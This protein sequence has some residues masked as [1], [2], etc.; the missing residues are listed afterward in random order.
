MISD[1][2]KEQDFYTNYLG[3]EV[4]MTHQFSGPE[5]EKIVGLPP[6]KA[7]DMRLLGDANSWFG[8]VELIEY[9]GVSGE[10]LYTKAQA[11][12]TGAL[13]LVFKTDDFTESVNRLN[14]YGDIGETLSISSEVYKGKILP[15]TTPAGFKLFING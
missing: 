10:N 3:L 15:V 1:A 4:C 9:Q 8:R 7:L 11:P 12:A 2:D 6:G 14:A 5:I 13:H